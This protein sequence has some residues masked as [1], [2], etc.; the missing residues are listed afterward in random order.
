[1]CFLLALLAVA[2]ISAPPAVAQNDNRAVVVVGEE[3]ECV[4][5]DEPELTGIEL[6]ERSTFDVT[7]ARNA[8]G[9]AV[10][11]VDGVGCSR[12]DCFCHYP[13]FWGYWTRDGEQW[14]FSQVGAAERVVTDGSIDGWRFGKDGEPA[15]KDVDLEEVC[16]RAIPASTSA[17]QPARETNLEV[18]IP[19]A[20]L[21][22]IA[23]A[24]FLVRRRRTRP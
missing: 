8:Q 5:F 4:A 7:T 1:V 18:A 12:D 2:A 14:S 6:L 24:V 23:G 9:A 11:R 19:F 16:T 22:T 21:L 3:A 20:A 17:R 15:P 13:E 10:C